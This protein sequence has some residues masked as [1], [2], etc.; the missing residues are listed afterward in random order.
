MN[1]KLSIPSSDDLPQLA[2]VLGGWQD[3]HGP[4]H[5]HPGD[6][7]WHSTRGAEATAAAIRTW[8]RLGRVLA[9]GLLDGPQLLRLAV[10]PDEQDDAELAEQIADDT[11]D[12]TRGVFEAGS[13]TIE[14]RGARRL[15]QHL[16]AHG[17]QPDEP[18]TPLRR[19]LAA[20]AAVDVRV[21]TIGVDRAE[22]WVEVHWSAFRG[23][24]F[25]IDDRHS[26]AARWRTMATGPFSAAARS[27]LAYDDHG[28]PVA[29]AT[30]WSAGP[31]RPGLIEPMGVH[32][33]QRGHGY[34]TAVT[35]A[36]IAALHDLDA[37]SALVC[38]ETSNVAAIS[39]Y[40]AA[41]FTPD[42]PVA[43]LSRSS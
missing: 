32:R 43:D 35:S 15:Q 5:L 1:I 9:L 38:T 12:P 29:V 39:T 31:G 21:E 41:G 19:D 14:A 36:A 27:L 18:W 4:L 37:S 6:L 30:V 10:D 2:E 3:D 40:I 24:P 16:R 33:D 20:P 17:W 25:T 28:H 7:G 22:E 26:F 42:E 11:A 13:A 34:G 23:T 8:S